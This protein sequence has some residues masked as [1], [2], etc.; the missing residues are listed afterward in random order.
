LHAHPARA[1]GGT[2]DVAHH[3]ILL[4]GA[5]EGLQSSAAVPG[6]DLGRRQLLK[7]GSRQSAA[8][9]GFTE[10]LAGRCPAMFL[11]R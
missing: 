8:P 9:V 5:G 2:L 11:E 4:V 3:Q 1:P 7:I 10:R 6:Q